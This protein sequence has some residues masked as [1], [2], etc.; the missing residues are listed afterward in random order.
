MAGQGHI[1]FLWTQEVFDEAR[2]SLISRFPENNLKIERTFD[3]IKA[4][5]YENEVTGF[6][7]LI[8]TLGC[9]DKD[10]EHVLAGA[11]H[12][13]AAV[14]LTYN[15]RDFPQHLNRNL[16]VLHPD[17]FLTLWLEARPELGVTLLAKW[18][19]RFESPPVDARTAGQIISKI[20]CPMLANFI[21]RKSKSIDAQ[22]Q[23]IRSSGTR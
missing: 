15:T 22:I 10:D 18:L 21:Q 1:Y 12:G 20:D 2:K 9:R 3:R 8:G 4:H 11:I 13:K 23:R 17:V 19:E 5:F 6:E 14:L 16:D 7:K